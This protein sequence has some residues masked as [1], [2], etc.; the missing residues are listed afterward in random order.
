MSL[1]VGNKDTAR[2]AW[3]TVNTMRI[4]VDRVRVANAQKLRREFSNIGF[5]ENQA[6]DDFTMWITGLPNN[7]R[8]LGD[9]ITDAEVVRKMLHCYWSCVCLIV[10][11]RW[12]S[13]SRPC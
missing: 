6:V 9:Q 8:L 3:E 12:P 2:E 1:L 13:P 10:L 11:C 7:L 4:G 5:K